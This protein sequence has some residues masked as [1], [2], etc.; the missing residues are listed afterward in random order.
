MEAVRELVA[1]GADVNKVSGSDHL[2]PLL[3]SIITGHFDIGKFAHRARYLSDAGRIEMHLE[4]L[5]D[6]VIA[7]DA[8][9]LSITFGRAETIHTESSYKFS[10]EDVEQLAH[11]SDFVLERSWT[12]E[13]GRFACNLLRC[14][15]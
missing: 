7:I 10:H 4:S 15:P 2:S 11:E 13:A 5:A 1:A 14:K 6:Q 8:L 3:Q 12:D 9:G